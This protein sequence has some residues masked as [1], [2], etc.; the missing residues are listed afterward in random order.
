M[1]FAPDI[2]FLFAAAGLGTGGVDILTGPRGVI[3]ATGAISV[4]STG[5]TG[6]VGTHNSVNVPAYVR[7]SAQIVCRYPTYVAAELKAQQAY[8]VLFPVRNRFVNGTWYVQINMLQSEPFPLP[9]DENNLMRFAFN[10]NCEKRL[11]AATS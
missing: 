7:P 3:P 5:G 4:I 8:A 10:V 2:V 1:S 11:S 9:E 6:P